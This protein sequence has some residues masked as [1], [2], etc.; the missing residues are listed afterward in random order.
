MY[1]GVR[2]TWL[3]LY[4]PHGLSD[5]TTAEQLQ[6]R[7]KLE[8]IAAPWE[9]PATPQPVDFTVN[10]TQPYVLTIAETLGLE[11]CAV[12][13]IP[14]LFSLLNCCLECSLFLNRTSEILGGAPTLLHTHLA[15]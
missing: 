8:E 13:D 12:I 3:E 14:K 9:G 4:L 2:S 7:L 11:V 1:T 6:G 5:D 10:L 15:L